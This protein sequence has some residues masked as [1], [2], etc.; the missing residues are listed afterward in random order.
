[1]RSLRR[2]GTGGV[3]APLVRWNLT[4][5]THASPSSDDF[6]CSEALLRPGPSAVRTTPQA[7]RGRRENHLLI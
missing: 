5:R 3:G 4:L 2:F 7:V 1:M 6:G